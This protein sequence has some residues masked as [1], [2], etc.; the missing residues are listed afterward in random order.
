MN[1]VSQ[2]S[3]HCCL[4]RSSSKAAI[5]KAESDAPP[6]TGIVDIIRSV[7]EQNGVENE[8]GVPSPLIGEGILS[9][10]IPISEL[11]ARNRLPEPPEEAVPTLEH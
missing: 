4:S 6:S 9:E 11:T 1:D 2:R 7:V 5:S 8:A 3:T 10:P